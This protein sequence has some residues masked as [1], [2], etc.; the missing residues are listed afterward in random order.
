MR[1]SGREMK[2]MGKENIVIL[3]GVAMRAISKMGIG[4]VRASFI[5]ININKCKGYGR[6][7][8]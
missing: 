4:M 6:K 1:D 3:M 5:M 2:K 8:N 7:G